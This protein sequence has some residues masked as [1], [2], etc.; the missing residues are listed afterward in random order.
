MPKMTGIV[1]T[2]ETPQTP[3]NY[4]HQ[5]LAETDDPKK[6]RQLLAHA[7]AHGYSE[8]GTTVKAILAKIK[9]GQK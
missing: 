6:L 2:P 1:E 3:N 9:G 4:I 8:S 7:R 5:Q